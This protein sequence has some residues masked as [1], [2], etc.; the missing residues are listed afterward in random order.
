ML[1]LHLSGGELP[2]M[3]TF[4]MQVLAIPA[5]ESPPKGVSAVLAAL[6]EAYKAI[7]EDSTVTAQALNSAF[8]DLT[9]PLLEQGL[10]I[11]LPAVP[12]TPVITQEGYETALKRS[13]GL[14]PS[15]STR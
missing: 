7:H 2:S 8:P 9:G 15:P 10:M 5:G 14:A 3:G 1:L 13:S 11:Y 12:T 6:G 4:P